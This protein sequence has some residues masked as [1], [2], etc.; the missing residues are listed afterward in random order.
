MAPSTETEGPNGP[1]SKD[2]QQEESN[3]L[4]ELIREEKGKHQGEISRGGGTATQDEIDKVSIHI[5]EKKKQPINAKNKAC[6]KLRIAVLAQEGATSPKFQ[7]LRERTFGDITVTVKEIRAAATAKSTTVRRLA[8]GLR[9]LAIEA[10]K[11]MEIDG[12]LSKAYRLEN[13]DANPQDL[14]WVSDFQTFSDNAGM[15]EALATAKLC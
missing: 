14:F 6:V 12:N 2:T 4:S 3:F 11:E 1:A 10:A 8:R 15:P 13:P 9:N 5:L 7:D